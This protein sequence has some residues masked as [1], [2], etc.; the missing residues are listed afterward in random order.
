MA[1]EVAIDRAVAIKE[2]L[3]SGIATREPKDS[4]VRPISSADAE[5]FEWGLDRFQKEAAVLVTFRHPNIVPVFRFFEA[6]S[7]A[8][9]VME[10]QDGRS[11]AQ[12]LHS[13]KKYSEQE[14]YDIIDPLI[15]GLERVHANNFLH[16]DIKPGNIYVREDGS[17]VLI[18]FGA[19]RQAMGQRSQNLTRIFTPGYAPHEQYETSGNQG[20]WTD[21]YA[22]GAVM[23]VMVADQPLVDALNR[24]SAQARKQPDPMTPAAEAARPG[25]SASLLATIDRSLAVMED[26]RPQSIAEF[27]GLLLGREGEEVPS[28]KIPATLIAGRNVVGPAPRRPRPPLG[29]PP[30]ERRAMRMVLFAGL[31]VVALAGAGLAT[32]VA[33]DGFG[34]PSSEE[35][36]R[37]NIEDAA[38]RRAEAKRAAEE[39]AKRKAEEAAKRKA[40]EVAKR[41][42]K[43]QAKMSRDAAARRKAEARKKSE[44]E[45]RRKETA[46]KKAEMARKRREEA[47]KKRAEAAA[48]RKV[49]AR[50]NA[51]AESGGRAETR[52]KA[53]SR[54]KAE[55]ERR[56]KGVASRA[57]AEAEARK[58][59]DIERQRRAEA[60]R[61][62]AEEARKK[63]EAE[64]RREG[65]KIE[66]RRRAEDERRRRIA[67]EE[68]RRQ[69]EIARRKAEKERS[70]R[71]QTLA[72]RVR[73]PGSLPALQR[74]YGR[75][76][77]GRVA[78]VFQR[79]LSDARGPGVTSRWRN[80]S[81][82]HSGTFTIL[83]IFR[84]QN[85]EFCRR[86]R[87]TVTVRGR[88]AAGNGTACLYGRSWRIVRYS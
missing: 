38:K 30:A 28:G 9:M 27:R 65:A 54:R 8:Y 7:T 47:A 77:C 67:A 84:G 16:R 73:C 32:Y 34:G 69:A 33:T 25:F 64:R 75:T 59:A 71:Q 26:D 36:A 35:I 5:E 24:L 3:P 19:A 55:E 76:D 12:I 46:A 68:T 17:P 70:R 22:I 42:A 57:K 74:L 6:N 2:Y 41:K 66:A 53:K 43:A 62:R 61:R 63:S 15:E 21:I 79:T 51:E 1:R 86:F 20:P 49:D 23:Y 80:G 39:A 58:K 88:I 56:R 10:Y 44:A 81:N 29:A 40:A 45:R 72:S 50:K 48:R 14:I 18:D 31:G 52:K 78:F 11:L 37:R 60:Q 13:G 82:G 87:Q 85:G 4:S 83:G